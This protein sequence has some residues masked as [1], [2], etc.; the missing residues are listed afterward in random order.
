MALP[1]EPRQKMINIMYLVLTAILALNVSSEILNAFKTMDESFV[2]SNTGMEDRITN[3][4]AGFDQKENMERFPEKVAEWKPRSEKVKELSNS[5]YQYLET[6]KTQ[7]KKES[8]QKNPND[9]YKEDDLEAATRMFTNGKPGETKGE[10]MFAILNKYKA[11]LA[12]IDKGVLAPQVNK[13]PNFTFVTDAIKKQYANLTPAQQFANAYFHM[14]PTV[15]AVAMLTKFQNDVK[16]SELQLIEHCY[17]QLNAVPYVPSFGVV[18][19]ASSG[20]VMSGDE[21]SITAGLGA[22][23]KDAQPV[24]TIDGANVPMDANGQAVLKVGTSSAGE[25]T[26]NVSI[27]YIDPTTN[28]KE[29]KTAQ[30]KYKVGTPTGLSL[31]TD[32]TR[33]FYIGAPGGNPVKISGAAGGAGSLNVSIASGPATITKTATPG[34]YIVTTTAEGDVFLNVSDGKNTLP[35]VRVPSKKMPPPQY[36]FVYGTM[37]DVTGKGGTA[38][39][40]AFKKQKGIGPKS[41][42]D[43]IFGEI[44]YSIKSYKIE[45]SGKGF[46]GV[47][48]TRVN[49]T[50]SFSSIKSY[51]D[52]CEAGS[53]VTISEIIALDAGGQ[54]QK[55]ASPIVFSLK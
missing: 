18:A 1:K 42:A 11:D 39:A 28:K 33:V 19:S 29:T 50:G 30:V 21:L 25:F 12:A 41:P 38:S 8:G 40:D 14:T 44:N 31:S 16:N 22:Y 5:V 7:L 23:A 10:E 55:I 49:N 15:A 24:V 52:R 4:I 9:P 17:S 54:D 20:L 36:A 47:E 32:K 27:T 51:L 6:L 3:L 2:R 35:K 48:T 13:L 37:D 53:S 34:E 46:N 45:F 26:K 43:F